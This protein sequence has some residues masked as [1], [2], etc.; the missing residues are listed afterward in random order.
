MYVSDP[1]F[2]DKDSRII[3]KKAEKRETKGEEKRESTMDSKVKNGQSKGA[4]NSISL[5]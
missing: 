4:Y 2:C 3:A 1:I 5:G